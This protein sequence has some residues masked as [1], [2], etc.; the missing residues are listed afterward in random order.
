MNC[1]S[2]SVRQMVAVLHSQR[3]QCC[4]WWWMVLRQLTTTP[5]L[6]AM[7]DG[8]CGQRWLATVWRSCWPYFWPGSC[9][10]SP[11]SFYRR[12]SSTADAVAFRTNWSTAAACRC[13]GDIGRQRG[14][15]LTYLRWLAAAAVAWMR[16][17]GNA[18]PSR[19][20]PMVM[21]QRRQ[22]TSQE[23][24]QLSPLP[25]FDESVLLKIN[26]YKILQ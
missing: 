10:P 17:S 4:A 23:A 8:C 19:R 16:V 11:F 15:Y 26:L 1:S 18:R 20:C 9:S 6:P 14:V 5:C 22:K 25:Q 12:S 3:S 2:R 7:S 24:L 21:L 13:V